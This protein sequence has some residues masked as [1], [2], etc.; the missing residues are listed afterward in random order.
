MR[1]FAMAW[2]CLIAL[3]C[4]ASPV[5]AQSAP[6]AGQGSTADSPPLGP[7]PRQAV[8]GLQGYTSD[9]RLVFASDP[10]AEAYRFECCEV[11]P[12]RSR[13][14]LEVPGERGAGR[15]VL[16]YRSGEQA[17]KILAFNGKSIEVLGSERLDQL[18]HAEL[19]RALFLFPDGVAW[20]RDAR[21]WRADLGAIGVLLATIGEDGLPTSVS[22]LTAGEEI[23]DSYKG[24]GW[25]TLDG[26]RW[27][28]SASLYQ[29]QGK[30]WDEQVLS[31]RTGTRYVDAFFLPPDRRELGGALH[32]ADDPP[33][34][35]DMRPAVRKR[36]LLAGERDREWDRVFEE[37]ARVRADLA[38]EVEAGGLVLEAF[39]YLELGEVGEAL[40]VQ[41]HASL[42][43][44][45][46][47]PGGWERLPSRPAVAVS[48]AS[49]RKVTA[50]SLARLRQAAGEQAGTGPILLQVGARDPQGGPAKLVLPLEN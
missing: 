34:A 49:L 39:Y 48:L 35:I 17:Y 36:V 21:L 13:W 8:A 19:R 14:C 47:L 12:A 3:W 10:A 22:S 18:L 33:R 40:A 38:A 11:F 25:Q 44:E 43:A 27:P 41:L 1:R 37:V 46:A 42:P 24:I 7:P 9:S 16:Q 30:V 5:A 20:Q 6:P 31:V 23:R 28:A 29:A 15:R 32:G 45:A 50:A 4:A 26:R 2:G